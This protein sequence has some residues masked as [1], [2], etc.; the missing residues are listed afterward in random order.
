MQAIL[1]ITVYGGGPSRRNIQFNDPTSIH[2][3]NKTN[4]HVQLHTIGVHAY[5]NV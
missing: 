2:K 1:K 5:N 3:I 4:R